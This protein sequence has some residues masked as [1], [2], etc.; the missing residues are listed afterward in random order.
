[1]R[2]RVHC[3][4]WAGPSI[5][6]ETTGRPES[7]IVESLALYRQ[8]GDR[9]GIGEVLGQLGVLAFDE[10]DLPRAH[11]LLTESLAIKRELGESWGIGQSLYGLGAV[12]RAQGKNAEARAFLE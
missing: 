11:S 7:S 12:A 5:M 8:G 6:R 1:M 9:R 2:L 10:T 3:T 4:T